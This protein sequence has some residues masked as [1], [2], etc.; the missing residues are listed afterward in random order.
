MHHLP[1]TPPPSPAPTCKTE[2]D[3]QS[4][5]RLKACSNSSLQLLVSEIFQVGNVILVN[6]LVHVHLM[7]TPLNSTSTYYFEELER[8]EFQLH[9]AKR[10]FPLLLT[11][12]YDCVEAFS[13]QLQR[14]V[15]LKDSEDRKILFRAEEPDCAF[16]AMESGNVA[17]GIPCPC[18]R[19]GTRACSTFDSYRRSPQQPRVS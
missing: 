15:Q 14:G 5:D 13:Y 12:L 16:G 1:P 4:S 11:G 19:Q 2:Q 10:T 18:K 6:V 17:F 3:A 8:H 7:K 9:R